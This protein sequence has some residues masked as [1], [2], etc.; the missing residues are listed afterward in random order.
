MLYLSF[1]KYFTFRIGGRNFFPAVADDFMTGISP[2][3]EQAGES[4]PQATISNSSEK[5]S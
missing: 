4:P 3:Q 5:L 2:G 1:W